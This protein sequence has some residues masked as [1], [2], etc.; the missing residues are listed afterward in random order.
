MENRQNVLKDIIDFA[1]KDENIR[2]LVL[3]GSLANPVD[4]IDQLSDLDPLFYVKDI[5]KLVDNEMW[6]NQFGD[7]I[8][9]VYDNFISKDNIKSYI[10]MV[11]YEGGLKV[12]FGIAPIELIKDI[13]DLRFY[14]VLIDKDGLITEEKVNTEENFY[15]NKPTSKE[16]QKLIND[17][18]W[19]INYISKSLR[20][21]EL[22]FAKFMF[23]NVYKMIRKLLSWYLGLNQNW[24]VNIGLEG[25]YLKLL[26]STDLWE[27]VLLTFA[28]SNVEDNFKAIY[29]SCDLVRE[30]GTYIA[31]QLDFVYPFELDITI[32][33]YLKKI[34]KIK[35]L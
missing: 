20:R 35:L 4:R 34:E 9:S 12:D 26:L 5:S 7:I 25:R 27:K 13:S 28:G 33:K 2:V 8:I 22:Y 1:I 11:I 24:E 16:Y 21:E 29:A 32:I 18:F 23:E 3:Q 15:S 14:K 10:K 31:S 17:F 19:D 30:L 6:L